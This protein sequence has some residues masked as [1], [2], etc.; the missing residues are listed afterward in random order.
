MSGHTNHQKLE[1]RT[2]YEHATTHAGR[3]RKICP[4]NS[5]NPAKAFYATPVLVT[6][7]CNRLRSLGTKIF[8]KTLPGRCLQRRNGRL[9]AENLLYLREKLLTQSGKI[10]QTHSYRSDNSNTNFNTRYPYQTPERLLIKN[11]SCR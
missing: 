1:R 4:S 6:T 11:P 9:T 10:I 7:T 8:G 3:K 2:T 5:P